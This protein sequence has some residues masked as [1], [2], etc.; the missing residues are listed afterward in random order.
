MSDR[1]T[2]DKVCQGEVMPMKDVREL[3]AIMERR[4][5]VTSRKRKEDIT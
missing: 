4:K 1:T 5:R 2:A 3:R